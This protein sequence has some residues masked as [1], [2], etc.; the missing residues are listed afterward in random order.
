MM[1][2]QERLLSFV[3]PENLGKSQHTSYAAVAF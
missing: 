1:A 2:L 3:K